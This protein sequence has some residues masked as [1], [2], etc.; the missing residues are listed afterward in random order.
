MIYLI[1][2]DRKRGIIREQRPFHTRDRAFAERERLAIEL[3]FRRSAVPYEVVLLEAA[4]EETL[5]RVHQRYFK[6]PSE[7]VESVLQPEPDHQ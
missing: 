4:D 1:Q 6:S 3:E 2:Y 5:K 7:I